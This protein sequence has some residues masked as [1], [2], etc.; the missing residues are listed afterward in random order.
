[1]R[2]HIE[3]IFRDT[4]YWLLGLFGLQ[5][6]NWTMYHE[7]VEIL[8]ASRSC[9]WPPKPSYIKRNFGWCNHVRTF[10]LDKNSLLIL[11]PLK[12]SCCSEATIFRIIFV[13]TVNHPFFVDQ[14]WGPSQWAL[15][16]PWPTQLS[17]QR[18]GTFWW[19]GSMLEWIPGWVETT[20][21]TKI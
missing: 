16:K 3:K 5:W 2:N 9:Q 20:N 14:N 17:L 6:S 4:F 12:N 21:Y 19:F 11:F 7:L 15:R 13:Y 10:S 8:V 1:M 18:R